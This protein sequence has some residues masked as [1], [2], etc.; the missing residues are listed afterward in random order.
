LHPALGGGFGKGFKVTNGFDL[1][2]DAYTGSNTP[3]PD[4]DPLDACGAASGASGHGTHVSG[5][6]AGFD[7]A[8]VSTLFIYYVNKTKD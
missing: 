1:V 5:I 8:T 2:G 7:K 6:I 4:S 3:K